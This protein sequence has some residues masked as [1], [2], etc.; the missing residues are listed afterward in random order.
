MSSNITWHASTLSREERESL[1]SA[2]G[3]VIWL[4]GLSGSGKS[5]IARSLEACLV[6]EGRYA[7]GLDGDNIRFGLCSDLGFTPEDR[8]VNI[9]RIGSVAQLFCDSGALTICSFVSPYQKDRDAVRALVPNRFIEI[10]VDCSVEECARR[11]PKGLYKKA[12]SG[13]IPN[14]TGVS[15]PYE[16]PL[17]P[18]IHLHSGTSTVDQCVEKIISFLIDQDLLPVDW[19]SNQ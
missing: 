5:T 19:R 12:L 15:A 7:Y 6:R 11:D 14:F 3:V 1:L 9:R 4:T 8:A 18:E 13:E 17:N 10:H 2:K 16:K